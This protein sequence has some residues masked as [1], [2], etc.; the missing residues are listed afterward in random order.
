[1][2]TAMFRLARTAARYTAWAR[3][4]TLDAEALIG[5]VELSGLTG[6]GGGAFPTHKKMRLMLAQ[7]GERKVLVVNG[8]EHEPGSLKDR[9]LLAQ[10]PQLVLEGALIMA[11]AV[12][13]TEI[14]VAI[15]RTASSALQAFRDAIDDAGH[16][17]RGLTVQVNE[18]PDSY[19]VGEETALLEVLEGRDA[20][21]RKKPPFPIEH[22]LHG[23]PTLIQNVETVAHLPLIVAEGVEAYRSLGV[24][25]CTLGEEFVH[26]GVHEVRLGT[27]LYEIL[28]EIGG[29]LRD[30]SRIKAIQTGGPSSGFLVPDQFG[31]LF[32]AGVLAKNGASLGCAVIRAYSE[33][34]CMVEAIARI[35]SFFSAGSC[36]QCPQCRME[37]QMLNAIMKQTLNGKGSWRLLD[38][39]GDILKMAE[40]AGLCSLIKMPVAPVV[41]GI[42]LFRSEFAA[43]IEGACSECAATAGREPLRADA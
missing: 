11:H 28:Y 16:E 20:L 8:S 17:L 7:A 14:V 34:D 38:R 36:G 39:V 6:K 40:G 23:L 4:M 24:T 2:R 21:P 42:D 29:G 3:A 43:H 18:V 41:S 30:G 13:A 32:D 27:S 26:A 31:L 37:T 33:N 1:M 25:L 19:L 35:T 12:G 15:N 9:Q 5:M 10:Y 22:G